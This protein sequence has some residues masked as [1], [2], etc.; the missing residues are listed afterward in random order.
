MP[1]Y[2]DPDTL[3]V[4]LKRR[5]K[6]VNDQA[7]RGSALILYREVNDVLAE[8]A[9]SGRGRLYLRRTKAGAVKRSRKKAN[10][11]QREFYRASK[12]G[13]APAENSGRL[14]GSIRITIRKT[15]ASVWT[16][17][18]YAKTLN[19]GTKKTDRIKPRPFMDMAI[20]RAR[21]KVERY[22]KSLKP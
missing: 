6:R 19:E 7:V 17:V 10:K 5:F 8:A 4:D 9:H 1:T 3:M 22:L 15:D 18:P 2:R 16:A 13:Q 20:K 14:R 11:G 21:P 12:A